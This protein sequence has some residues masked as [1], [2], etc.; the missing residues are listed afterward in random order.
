MTIEFRNGWDTDTATPKLG[1]RELRE[2]IMAV[3][4]SYKG[5]DV[6][7][8]HLKNMGLGTNGLQKIFVTKGLHQEEGPTVKDN[9]VTVEY[10]SYPN[11][12]RFHIYMMYVSKSTKKK[13]KAKKGWYAHMMTYKVL[14]TVVTTYLSY[15]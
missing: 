15:I 8:K 12:K 14:N 2:K 6:E 1:K 10:P 11:S 5:E 9:H 3:L 13:K 7:F 4:N